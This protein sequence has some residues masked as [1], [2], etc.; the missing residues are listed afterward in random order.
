MTQLNKYII[1][2]TTAW[3]GVYEDHA[4]LAE[5][6]I[7]LYDIAQCLAYDLFIENDGWQEV[8][9]ECGY[10]PETMTE[11][12]WDSLYETT[13]EAMYY[14]YDIEIVD[15]SDQE[16]LEAWKEYDLVYNSEKE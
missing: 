2:C 7:E 12:E 3:C 4:A 6:E 14:G 10:D 11:E 1:H 16:A 8:A 5:S 15:E 9:E 13:D